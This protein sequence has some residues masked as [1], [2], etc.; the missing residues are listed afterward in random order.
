MNEPGRI[1][2]NYRRRLGRVTRGRVRQVDGIRVVLR[3]AWYTHPAA[4]WPLP[5]DMYDEEGRRGPRTA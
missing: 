3:R 1:T 4:T 5:A 2:R